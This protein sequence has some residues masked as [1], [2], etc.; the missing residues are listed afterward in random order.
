M[1]SASVRGPTLVRSKSFAMTLSHS[2]AAAD[3]LLRDR[4]SNSAVPALYRDRHAS[5]SIQLGRRLLRRMPPDQR[6]R[7]TFGISGTSGQCS[8]QAVVDGIVQ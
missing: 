8:Q 6:G 4:S 1:W 2:S 7:Q 3:A 5:M